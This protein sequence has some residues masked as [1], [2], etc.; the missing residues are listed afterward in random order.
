MRPNVILKFEGGYSRPLLTNDIQ[1]R[2][3]SGLNDPEVNRYLDAVKRSKQTYQT[4]FNFIVAN[5]QSLNSVLWGIWDG[6]SEQLFGTVR[7]HEIEFHHRTAHIGACLFDKNFWGKGLGKKAIAT[8]TKW[9][10]IDLNLRWVEANIWED[11]LASQ[12][13]FISAGY[14]WKCDISGKYI[15]EGKPAVNKL[16][17]AERNI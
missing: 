12:K 15:F 9:A 17:A 5:D 1:D 13:A 14:S 2:Y 10:L 16:F 4:V 3:V 8:V 11:N 7:L 6:E